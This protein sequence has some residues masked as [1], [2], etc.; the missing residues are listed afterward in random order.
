MEEELIKE[1]DEYVTQYGL[2]EMIERFEDKIIRLKNPKLSLY[3][4]NLRGTKTKK[5]GEIILHSKDMDSICDFAISHSYEEGKEQVDYLLKKGQAQHILKYTS[6]IYGF[7]YANVAGN[8]PI[9]Y[10]DTLLMRRCFEA[11]VNRE[12]P[13]ECYEL[14]QWF[15]K[16]SVIKASTNTN[17]R[18]VEK[19]C[20][21]I[22]LSSLKDIVRKA[23]KVIIDSQN[24]QYNYQVVAVLEHLPEWACDR[25]DYSKYSKVVIASHSGYCN[26]C[27]A[28]DYG[29]KDGV[30]IRKHEE[31]VINSQDAVNNYLYVRDVEGADVLAHGTI[32]AKYGTA[33]EN[34][35]YA[36][37]VEGADKELHGK[38][39]AEALPKD[40]IELQHPRLQ[41]IQEA[42]TK[43]IFTRKTAKVL[44]IDN[45]IRRLQ[46]TCKK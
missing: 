39:I 3:F 13:K 22:I 10:T 6:S 5:H 7:C 33:A 2:E 31:E 19:D 45:K 41:E 44:E 29:Q 40:I 42:L 11:I 18:I 1:L 30:D 36:T 34:Y 28:R 46:S 27:Y 43:T 20:G 37:E 9:K 38:I 24:A 8:E 23:N 12:D 16:M 35:L 26:Y 21:Y 14:L 32:V 25:V 17:N 15:Q 4:S